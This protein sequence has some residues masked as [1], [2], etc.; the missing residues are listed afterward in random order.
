LP[1][2]VWVLLKAQTNYSSGTV[3]V[4]STNRIRS[5]E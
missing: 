2:I 4:T 3:L 5:G 1:F